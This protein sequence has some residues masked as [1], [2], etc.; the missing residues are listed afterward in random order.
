VDL[1]FGDERFVHA[2]PTGKQMHVSTLS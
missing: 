1:Y 2:R